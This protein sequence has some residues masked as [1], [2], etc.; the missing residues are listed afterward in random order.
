MVQPGDII[1]SPT[2]GEERVVVDVADYRE[3]DGTESLDSVICILRYPDG[4][5]RRITDGTGGDIYL[6][7][8]KAS[9]I[10]ET[11]RRIS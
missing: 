4:D 8:E 11:G 6:F 2:N 10:R 5:P 7:S 1:V 9:E 3:E